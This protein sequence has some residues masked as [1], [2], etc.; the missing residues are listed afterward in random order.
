MGEV[1]KAEER[2]VV[3][4]ALLEPSSGHTVEEILARLSKTESEIHQL[5]GHI[6]SFIG[7]QRLL[8]TLEGVADIHINPY[9]KLSDRYL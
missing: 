1:I 4:S 8:E 3:V 9:Q 7:E 5:G 2:H 6:V